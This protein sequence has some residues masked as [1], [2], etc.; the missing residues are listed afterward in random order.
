M[1]TSMHK[2]KKYEIIL[3]WLGKETSG[4]TLNTGFLNGAVRLLSGTAALYKIF[5]VQDRSPCWRAQKHI[6]PVSGALSAALE[7]QICMVF[8][9]QV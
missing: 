5:L 2:A 4:P 8:E 1:V 6:P 3:S 9:A 7:L